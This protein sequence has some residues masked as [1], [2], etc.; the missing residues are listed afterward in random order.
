M[1][2]GIPCKHKILLTYNLASLVTLQLLFTRRKYAYLVNLFNI[3]Q[4]ESNPT[5]VI[6]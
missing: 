4:I 3:I 1:D 6:G 5:T 2:M